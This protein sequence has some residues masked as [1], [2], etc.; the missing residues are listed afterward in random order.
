MNLR[1]DHSHRI[2][3]PSNC[4]LEGSSLW[5]GW[6]GRCA[7][8]VWTTMGCL[9]VRVCEGGIPQLILAGIFSFDL[10]ATRGVIPFNTN[11]SNGSLGSNDDEE[12]CKL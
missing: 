4:E 1:K 7:A 9:P 6:A 10:K 3:H 2:F 12:R 8:P 11:F 5:S